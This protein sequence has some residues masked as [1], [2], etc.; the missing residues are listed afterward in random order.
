MSSSIHEMSSTISTLKKVKKN[1]EIN[2]ESWMN[3]ICHVKVVSITP[4]YL[5]TS[6]DLPL[7]LPTYFLW[8]IYLPTNL[9]TYLTTFIFF[10]KYHRT[11]LT[12]YLLLPTFH[13]TNLHTYLQPIH[14]I[15]YL[16]ITTTKG[17]LI[18]QVI[19]LYF[20]WIH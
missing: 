4:T 15:I 2:Y 5:F 10:P 3:F 1:L 14:L 19:S 11:Y 13:L 17:V 6:Y 7:Y 16:P 9:L 18:H 8:L 20:E 12:T